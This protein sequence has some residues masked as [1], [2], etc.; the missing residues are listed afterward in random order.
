MNPKRLIKQPATYLAIAILVLL[1]H[2][3][4]YYQ[5]LGRDAVDDAYISFRYAQNLSSGHGLVFNP[6]ER[7]EGYTNF[8]WTLLLAPLINLGV[9]P[10]PASMALGALF[11]VGTLILIWR[12]RKEGALAVSLAMLLL[13][14]DGSFALWSVAG[15]E[16]ALF[17]FLLW[18]AMM[19]YLRSEEEV[20]WGFLSGALFA[21][22]AMTRPE[23]VLVFAVTMLHGT[24]YHLLRERRFLTQGDLARAI[25]FLALYGSYFLWRYH[26]YGYLLPNTFYAKVATQGIQAQVERGFRHLRTFLGVHLSWPLLLLAALA[27]G[28]GKTRFTSTYLA[29]VILCYGAYIVYVG[30]DWSVGRFFMP[31]LPPFYLLVAQ[32][33]SA[34]EESLRSRLKGRDPWLLASRAVG[35]VAILATLMALFW[36]SSFHGE[37]QLFIRRFQAARATRARVAMGRWLAHN[38]PPDTYI[39]VD[40]AGQIPYYSRLKTLDMFGVNDLH[41]AHMKVETMGQGVPGHEKLDLDYVIWQKP[42]LIIVTGNFLDGVEPYQRVEWPWTEEESLRG[43]LTIYRRKG[44]EG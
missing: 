17:A 34:L 6:G 1:G 7:V 32:G 38:V 8:L 12:F 30:G 43:F 10:G 11:G 4:F 2:Q 36:A 3:A 28:K 39:A 15:M 37:D 9:E 29:S 23:G 41:T 5:A 35:G 40:A 18:A 13:A 14:V 25:A 42:D 33:V 19:A 16:T 22:A 21:L 31:L 44:W 20:R 24:L 27:L 26:Y